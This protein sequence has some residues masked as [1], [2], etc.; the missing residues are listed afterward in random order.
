MACSLETEDP[1]ELIVLREA[2]QEN[3]S[4]NLEASLEIESEE[5]VL[6][7]VRVWQDYG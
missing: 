3:D 7:M 5:E 1:G 6:G 4:V 2:V